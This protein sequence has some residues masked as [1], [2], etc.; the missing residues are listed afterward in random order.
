MYM[1]LD[2]FARCRYVSQCTCTCTL[3]GPVS[4]QLTL[5]LLASSCAHDCELVLWCS[6]S[7]VETVWAVVV[8]SGR[9]WSPLGLVQC[10]SDLLLWCS[11]DSSLSLHPLPLSALPS[12]SEVSHLFVSGMA[13]RR[14]LG[15]WQPLPTS[16]IPTF[17][18]DVKSHMC[19]QPLEWD[20]TGHWRWWGVPYD[21]EKRAESIASVWSRGDFGK[22][23]ER[24][25]SKDTQ[26]G[27]GETVHMWIRDAQRSSD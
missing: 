8:W 27:A 17:P 3:P 2:P 18:S 12:H 22:D 1:Q 19:A 14:C 4:Y 16:E 26:N 5:G 21:A 10:L 15:T 7:R 24:V 25:E 13:G 11:H 6:G 9:Q 23:E 20:R